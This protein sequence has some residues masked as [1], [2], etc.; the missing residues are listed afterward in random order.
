MKSNEAFL[1]NTVPAGN[2]TSQSFKIAQNP[3]A[4]KRILFL[5][6]SITLHEIK[7]SIGWHNNWGMAASAEENDFVHI[8]LNSLKEKYGKIS[9]CIANVSKW[10]RNY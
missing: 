10:E 5:G 4:S 2:Q 1:N 9:Y 7:P 6:N 3:N 8:V